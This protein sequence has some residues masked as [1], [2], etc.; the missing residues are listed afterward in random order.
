MILNMRGSLWQIRTW[1]YTL[2]LF[3]WDRATQRALSLR[4]RHLCPEA[5]PALL[6][7]VHTVV[8]KSVRIFFT[9]I[10]SCQSRLDSES[11]M[12]TSFKGCKQRHFFS[13]CVYSFTASWRSRSSTR[14]SWSSSSCLASRWRQRTQCRR[15]ATG[16][17]RRFGLFVYFSNF[18]WYVQYG[19]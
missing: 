16:Q 10:Q 14:S 1:N 5:H 13:A 18:S 7:N 2:S 8:H 17:L 12:S 19:N 15:G 3:Q 4:W 9:S 6:V 11:I